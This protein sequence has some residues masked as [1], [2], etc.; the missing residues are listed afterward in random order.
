MNKK[1]KWVIVVCIEHQ[2]VQGKNGKWKSPHRV[3]WWLII[4]ILTVLKLLLA[5]TAKLSRWLKIVV[6]MECDCPVHCKD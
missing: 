2:K 3:K 6:E 4:V 5:V 1:K